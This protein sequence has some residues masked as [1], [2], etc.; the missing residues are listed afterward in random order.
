MSTVE[1]LN[2][3]LRVDAIICERLLGSTCCTSSWYGLTPSCS[4]TCNL[5]R[6][7]DG[8]LEKRHSVVCEN[9]GI[10]PVMDKSQS[11]SHHCIIHTEPQKS[12]PSR[13]MHS[14]PCTVVAHTQGCNT[15]YLCLYVYLIHLCHTHITFTT[16]LRTVQGRIYG[17]GGEPA[18]SP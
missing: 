13:S 7:P 11:I 1:T 17:E 14:H 3:C 2:N 12:S 4:H 16:H 6:D 5:G 18:P 10:I 9:R 8:C 15:R